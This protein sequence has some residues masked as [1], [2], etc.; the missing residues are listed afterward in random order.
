M[1]R[2]INLLLV[3]IVGGNVLSAEFRGPLGSPPSLTWDATETRAARWLVVGPLTSA[4]PLSLVWEGEGLRRIERLPLVPGQESTWL[5]P[6]TASMRRAELQGAWNGPPVVL[7]LTSK[8]RSADGVLLLKNASGSWRVDFPAWS[9]KTGWT[10]QLEVQVQAESGWTVQVAEDG[11]EQTFA[12]APGVTFWPYS[13]PAW[14]IFPRRVTLRSSN[15]SDTAFSVL[16]LHPTGVPKEQPLP[17]DTASLVSWPAA[18][19]RHPDREW[20]QWTATPGVLVL[21]TRTYALQDDY[22]KRLAF[23]VEKTGWRGI[24]GTDGQLAGLHGW[25][26]HDY[27][28]TDLAR[29]F[30]KAAA[31]GFRLNDRERELQEQLTAAGILVADGAGRWKAGSGALLGVSI[32]S[33]PSLRLFL[34]THEAFHG[35]YF[36]NAAYRAGV[37]SVWESLNDQTRQTF[38]SFLARSSYD[39]GDENLMVNEFHAYVLQQRDENWLPYFRQR[40]TTDTLMLGELERAANALQTLTKNLF[41][42]ASGEVR[43]VIPQ[44]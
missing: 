1:F 34:F 26:A 28:S 40:I 30:N 4:S 23:F 36:V 24:L 13:P 3:L 2:K 7:Q 33:P 44:N 43:A 19:W 11:R 42:L 6:I 18:S 20:F 29:F 22:L 10:A 15:P 27:Q 38:R 21:V 5:L 9:T 32:E 35:L 37:R 8:P 31:E 12:V 25:N 14:G 16:S 39:P 17:A 41:G